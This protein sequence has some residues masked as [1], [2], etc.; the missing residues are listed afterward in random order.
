MNKKVSSNQFCHA[1]HTYGKDAIGTETM[2]AALQ[3]SEVVAKKHYNSKESSAFPRFY[4]LVTAAKKTSDI[5][6]QPTL[7]QGLTTTWKFEQRIWNFGYEQR[8]KQF[9]RSCHWWLGLSYLWQMVFGTSVRSRE[10]CCGAFFRG[11]G[12]K[13][14]DFLTIVFSD[15]I[16]QILSS[17]E[18][19]FDHLN[20]FVR[21]IKIRYNIF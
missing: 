4:D 6:M 5:E 15:N 9:R 7:K 12:R 18:N 11:S 1:M 17:F 20:L 19:I 8:R 14:V 2:A 16:Q 3:H 21:Y 10:Q 13:Q